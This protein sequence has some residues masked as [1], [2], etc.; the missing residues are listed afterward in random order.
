MPRPRVMAAA[1]VTVAVVAGCSGGGNGRSGSGARPQ[2]LRATTT[3]PPATTE[4]QPQPTDVKPVLRGLV[5]R[6]G[7]P[8]PAY[9]GV[10]H[11]YVVN[12]G[13]KNLQPAP[14]GP[15]TP[16]NPIDRALAAVRV[17]NRQQ[18]GSPLGLKVRLFAGV[19]A[20]DW[21]KNLGGPPF[22]VTDK[23]SAQSGTVGRFWTDAFGRA[24]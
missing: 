7:P 19:Q 20:P 16:D 14:N 3:E 15:L 18:P 13:W 4:T 12:V 24:Y 10:V 8:P 21:A 9:R 1:L 23:A 11:A 22:T 2:A 6:A 5:D 17:M